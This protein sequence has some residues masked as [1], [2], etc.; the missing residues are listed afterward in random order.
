MLVVS[1][2]QD[3]CIDSLPLKTSPALRAGFDSAKINSPLAWAVIGER[4]R[5]RIESKITTSFGASPKC[6][7]AAFTAWRIPSA[8]TPYLARTFHLNVS[9]SAAMQNPLI[10]NSATI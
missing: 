6:F 3:R 2:Y 5:S 7:F 4:E 10:K 1:K 9:A 8:V